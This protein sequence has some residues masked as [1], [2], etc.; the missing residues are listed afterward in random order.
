[1]D[2]EPEKTQAVRRVMH[3]FLFA[4]VLAVC[5]ALLFGL[6]SLGFRYLQKLSHMEADAAPRSERLQSA[7]SDAAGERTVDITYT[8]LDAPDDGE[9]H[10]QV[11]WDDAWFAADDAT[12]NQQLAHTAAVLSALAYSESGYYKAGS[13]QPAYMEEA[14]DKLGFSEISTESYRYR[15]E[16]M[17]EVLNLVT[18]ETD[19]VAYTI[20]RRHLVTVDGSKRDLILVSVR[21]SYGSEWLSNLDLSDEESGDHGGYVR[22]AQDIDR[23]IATWAE[24]SARTGAEVSV[25]LVGHSRGGAVANLAAA[26]LDDAR[27]RTASAEHAAARVDRVYAYTFASPCT[28]LNAGAQAERYGNIFN[29][30]NPSDLMPFLPLKDWGYRRYGVDLQ[31][32]EVGTEGFDERYAAMRRSYEEA[33]RVASASDPADKGTVE[34]VVDALS[35]EVGSIEQLVTPKGAA[36]VFLSMSANVDPVRILHSHYPATYVAWLSVLDAEDL[37]SAD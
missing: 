13:S 16:I 4:S 11:T 12:Y 26:D 29:I 9:A 25:L 22:A 23:E 10:S 36:A 15:S 35:R 28:T 31:L 3:R 20:A 8:S 37:L 32:P 17:D 1:M 14:L 21:G 18:D 34:A 19:T 6:T 30:V 5:A 33:T 27:V 2:R 24:E 7:L